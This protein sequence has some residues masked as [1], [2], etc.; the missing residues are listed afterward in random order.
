MFPHGSDGWALLTHPTCE[1]VVFALFHITLNIMTHRPFPRE[2]PIP[3]LDENFPQAM[4]ALLAECQAELEVI[5]SL[6]AL[7]LEEMKGP[8]KGTIDALKTQYLEEER[9]SQDF[10][11]R[12]TDLSLYVYKLLKS[13]TA[14]LQELRRVP[15]ATLSGELLSERQQKIAWSTGVESKIWDGFQS[16]DYRLDDLNPNNVDL[17][18][19]GNCA[20]DNISDALSQGIGVRKYL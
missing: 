18:S 17:P 4:P 7:K 20:P 5:N 9:Y 1:I 11:E 8:G 2:R 3:E 6:S 12:R 15:T 10:L 14:W 13:K 19:S 16:I